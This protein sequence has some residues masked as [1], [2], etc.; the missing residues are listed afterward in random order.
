V[1]VEDLGKSER[2]ELQSR[3]EVLLAHLL[4]WRLQPKRRTRSWNATIA[5]RRVKIRQL[6]G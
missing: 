6:P 4:K 5:V 3:L 2:R 1:E